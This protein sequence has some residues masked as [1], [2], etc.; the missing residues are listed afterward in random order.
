MKDM[1]YINCPHCRMS[2]RESESNC[3]NCEK[4]L[5]LEPEFDTQEAPKLHG[6][7]PPDSGRKGR[8]VNPIDRSSTVLQGLRSGAV[9]GLAW[10]V[11]TAG[12][13]TAVGGTLIIGAVADNVGG[14]VGGMIGVFL[15]L[16]CFDVIY[17]AVMGA[18]LGASG[19][20]C[21]QQ[22]GRRDWRTLGTF[23]G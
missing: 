10:G 23:S 8:F 2:N 3:Y 15:I 11:F 18:I 9:A 21:Y 20:L 22:V 17:G 1:K 16:L 19:T 4:S 5:D 12:A 7:P 14:F 6:G 13:K